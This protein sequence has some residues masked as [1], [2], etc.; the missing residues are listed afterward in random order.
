MHRP[1]PGQYR[2]VSTAG[3]RFGAFVPALLPPVPSPEWSPAL[4]SR[5]DDA[6]VALG[7]LDAVS[8]LL[9]NAAL[10]FC[11]FMRMEA[12]LAS[13]IEARNHHW[14]T[15]CFTR[16]TST[17]GC[18]STMHTKSVITSRRWSMASAGCAAAFQ[19]ACT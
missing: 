16:S 7:R 18:R 17:P 8:A 5:F 9:P 15:C 13:Q 14:R 10:V 2:T 19:S 3:E 12:A 4:R 11:S 1:T 6:L